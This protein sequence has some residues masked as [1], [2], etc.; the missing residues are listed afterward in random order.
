MA[1]EKE[2]KSAA[3][4]PAMEAVKVENLM[5]DKAVENALAE[6]E[7]EKD[8]E[9]AK[10]AKRAICIATFINRKAV[11]Q[12]QARRRED[13]ITKDRLEKTK[14][15]YE[16]LL[17]VETDIVDGRLVPNK[18]SVSAEDRLTP[19]DFEKELQKLNEE[20]RK[21]MSESS[22][23]YDNLMKELRNSYEGQYRYWINEY[24]D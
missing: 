21:K 20:T 16:R 1:K 6:I 23:T 11:Y 12:L 18:K 24:W 5:T 3:Q 22:E 15:L 13:D 19:I 2:K 9:K 14:R 7:K 17:G 10:Q 4:Q 8:E